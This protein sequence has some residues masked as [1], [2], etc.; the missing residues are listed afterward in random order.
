LL[1]HR[2]CSHCKIRV[3]IVANSKTQNDVHGP[4]GFRPVLP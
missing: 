3:D 4:Q 2:V 1:Q